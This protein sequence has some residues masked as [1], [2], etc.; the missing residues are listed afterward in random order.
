MAISLAV[1][2]GLGRAA[3]IVG[4]PGLGKTRLLT[5]WKD[6]TDQALSAHSLRWIEGHCLSYGQSLAYHLLQSLLRSLLNVSAQIGEA[7]TRAA[8]FKLTV[9]FLGENAID[10]YPYLAH[11]LSLKLEGQAL[12]RVQQLDPQLLQTQYLMSL[13][14]LLTA[15]SARQ[16]LGLLLEDIHWADPS[17]VE[18]L[19]KLL[20]LANEA[21]ILFC[22]VTRPEREVPGW[23]LVNTA[24]DVLGGRLTELTLRE[25]T[26]ADSQQLVA[27]LLSNATMPAAARN[28]IFQKAEGNP[29]FVE[30]IIRMLI[31]RGALVQ[32]DGMWIAQGKIA[33]AEIPDNLQSLLLAR[34][35]RLPED[36]KRVLRVASVI[37]RQFSVKVLEKVLE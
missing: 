14:R 10:S 20:S 30:E 3:V 32:R 29:F 18:L 27:N 35:D 33:A 5:E 11:L 37:G 23:K 7:E 13:R 15:L 21:P 22:F 17:S 16:P 36:V 26:E 31:E 8:L 6:A 25:L 4:E 2:A 9:E 28:L 12:E 24:R 19:G 1:Q 34:I